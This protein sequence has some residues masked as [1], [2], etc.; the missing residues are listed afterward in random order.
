MTYQTDD[1]A[2]Q[3]HWK[4]ESSLN[5]TMKNFEMQGRDILKLDT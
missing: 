1:I 3:W 2:N 5:Q 4:I